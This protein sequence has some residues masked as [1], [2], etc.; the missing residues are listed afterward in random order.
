[1]FIV[2]V[3]VSCTIGHQHGV[4]FKGVLLKQFLINQNTIKAIGAWRY[5]M[6]GAFYLHSPTTIWGIGAMRGDDL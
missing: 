3:P 4:E 2:Y 5:K 1:M 6:I